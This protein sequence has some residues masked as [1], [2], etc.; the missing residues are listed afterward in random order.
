MHKYICVRDG[1]G[2]HVWSRKIQESLNG[3]A[4]CAKCMSVGHG[5]HGSVVAA[6]ANHCIMLQKRDKVVG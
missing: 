1:A 6:P 3:L 5:M 2:H 4:S